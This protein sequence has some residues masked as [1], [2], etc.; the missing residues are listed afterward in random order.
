MSIGSLPHKS[1]LLLPTRSTQRFAKQQGAVLLIVLVFSLLASLL[2]VTSIRDNLVQERLSGNFQKQI[3]AQLTAE[4]GMH[5]SYN[6]LKSTLTK[7]PEST[8][9]VLNNHL[10][11]GAAGKIAHS[12]YTLQK[13]LTLTPELSVNSA[14]QHLEAKAK[15]NA[16][17]VLDAPGGNTIFNDAIVSCE[18]LSLTGSSTIDGYD[19]RKGAYGANVTDDQGNSASNKNGK[20]NVTTVEPN[21]NITLTGNAPI[22][23][24]VSATGNVNLTGSSPIIG[25]VQSNKDVTVGTGTIT[26]NVSAGNNFSLNNSGT[27]TGSVLANNNASTVPSANINGT[28]QYGGIGTFDKDSHIGSLVN[29]N[30]NVPPVPTKSCDPLNISSIMGGFKVAGNSAR[31]IGATQNVTITPTGSSGTSDNHTDFPAL[32][33]SSENIFGKDTP[34]FNLDSLVMGS[35]G[36]LNISGGDVTLIINGD[37]KM[38]GSNQLN[39][40]KDSSLTLFVN[41]EIAF[42]GGTNA[43]NDV[44][45]MTLTSG[46]KP[47]VSIYSGS[48]KDVTVSGGVPIYAALYAPKAKVNLPGG[49][50]IFGAVRGKSITASGDGKIHYD[51]ALGAANLGTDNA[52]PPQLVLKNWQYL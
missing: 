30:P 12:A 24:D 48:D 20:G 34:V 13:K 17:F 2:V 37:F 18:S 1:N 21:A 33:S 6:A 49:P 15:L 46:G 9:E 11:N 51:N 52:P 38:G 5:D 41:G 23:G 36:I 47:P 42:T 40:A 4:Q 31:T 28:L 25:N 45:S 8:L 29:S 32:T 19:S 22:Y 39:I 10:A 27:I 43:G 7:K 44:K 3:N 26:G 14:G 35:D 50:D 16:L